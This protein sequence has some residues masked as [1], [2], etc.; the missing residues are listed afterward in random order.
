MSLK[1]LSATSFCNF[2]IKIKQSLKNEGFHRNITYGIVFEHE[3]DD[4]RWVYED[5]L[6]GLSQE[7]PSGVFA[8]PDE[9]SD[10]KR[11]NK[12]NAITKKPVNVELPT[13]LSSPNIVYITGKVTEGRVN[14]WLPVHARYHQAVAGGGSA[15]NLIEPPKLF[16]HCPDGR[17]EV[18]GMK[19]AHF[20]LRC[21]GSS[22]EKCNWKNMPFTMMTDILIWEVPVGNKDHFNFVA[23]GTAT[24]LVSGSLYLLKTIHKY[25]VSLRKKKF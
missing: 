25:E 10:L 21:S 15:R 20:A 4:E 22:N 1:R 23:I 9:L 13:E 3:N 8:N 7:L 24:V 12:L 18:C 5:C 17:L 16:L 14:L 19:K 6:V 2:N 11:N